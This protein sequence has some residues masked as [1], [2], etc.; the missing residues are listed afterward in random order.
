MSICKFKSGQAMS[1]DNK[2]NL[3]LKKVDQISGKPSD[4]N[5]SISKA[6]FRLRR[7]VD[8][9]TGKPSTADDA[10]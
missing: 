2:T 5:D 9:V 4:A 10:I 1:I 6:A 3:A 7:K 8:P